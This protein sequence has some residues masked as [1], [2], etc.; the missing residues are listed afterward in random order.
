[1]FHAVNSLEY[2]TLFDLFVIFDVDHS[3][4]FET[5]FFLGLHNRL[6]IIFINLWL[7]LLSLVHNASF[8]SPIWV[9]TLLKSSFLAPFSSFYVPYGD[10]TLSM[11]SVILCTLMMTKYTSSPNSSTTTVGEKRNGIIF[12]KCWKKKY[13]LNISG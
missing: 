13:K 9:L 2:F 6:P 8:F 10:L 11:A 12:S 4:F 7:F 3:L 1:M 5:V